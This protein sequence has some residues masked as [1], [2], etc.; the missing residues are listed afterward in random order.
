[1]K[2]NLRIAAK[3]EAN[4]TIYRKMADKIKATTPRAF[5]VIDPGPPPPADKVKAAKRRAK[6][7]AKIAAKPRTTRTR[8]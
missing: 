3:R 6:A 1:M 8:K 4:K 7:K 2:G 5:L